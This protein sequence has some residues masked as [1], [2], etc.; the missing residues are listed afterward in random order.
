MDR[1]RQKISALPKNEYH[2]RNMDLHPERETLEFQRFQRFGAPHLAKKIRLLETQVSY[3]W[4]YYDHP[5]TLTEKAKN[6]K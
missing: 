4:I 5:T 6:P 3:I 1:A 2:R